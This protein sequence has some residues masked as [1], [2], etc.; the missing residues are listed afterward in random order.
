MC[1]ALAMAFAL[2]Y[3]CFTIKYKLSPYVQVILDHSKC[4]SNGYGLF[5][6]KN[7]HLA[8]L[9]TKIHIFLIYI[10]Y[11]VYRPNLVLINAFGHRPCPTAYSVFKS[12]QIITNFSILL[13][14]TLIGVTTLSF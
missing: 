7:K 12:V 8:N 2:K 6:S 5:A 11:K 3:Q 13:P 1:I 4:I 10:V 9:P 14:N